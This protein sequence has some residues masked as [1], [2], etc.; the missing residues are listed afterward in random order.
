MARESWETAVNSQTFSGLETGIELKESTT[1]T[2]ISPGAG[3]IGKAFAIPANFF[4]VGHYIRITAGGVIGVKITTEPTFELTPQ[5]HTAA[6]TLGT[7]GVKLSAQTFKMGTKARKKLG[8]QWESI[9]RI[10]VAGVA[11]KMITNGKFVVGAEAGIPGETWSIPAAE[12]AS[13][14]ESPTFDNSVEGRL[15]FVLKMGESNALN[16][17]QQTTWLIE[18]LN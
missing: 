7:E 3:T 2:V 9:S 1:A 11:A 10:T 4:V 6:Q 15:V 18:I 12:L 13:P 5:W 8:W 14:F 16:F 17:M